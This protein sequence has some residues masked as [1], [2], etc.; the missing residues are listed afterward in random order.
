M[1]RVLSLY[2]IS[3]ESLRNVGESSREERKRPS[4]FEIFVLPGHSGDR[5]ASLPSRDMELIIIIGAIWR[6]A[7]V[8]G[9]CSGDGSRPPF[10]RL[11]SLRHHL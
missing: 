11:D 2:V 3:F 4:L 8:G 9:G 7:D 6:T 5:G 10:H 1:K